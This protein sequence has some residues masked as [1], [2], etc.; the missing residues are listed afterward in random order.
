MTCDPCRFAGK[1]TLAVKYCKDCKGHFC[2][3][4]SKSHV[5]AS[6][7]KTHEL[8]SVSKTRSTKS[9]TR[10][11][12]KCQDHGAVLI[13]YCETHEALCCSVCALTSH[14]GCKKVIQ[15]S[16]AAVGKRAFRMCKDLESAI[17]RMQNH[18]EEVQAQKQEYIRSVEQQLDAVESSINMFRKSVNGILNNLEDA[19]NKK[20]DDIYKE[21]T[22]L[23][24]SH[25]KTSQTAINILNDAYKQ[26]D[27][28]LKESDSEMFIRTKRVQGVVQTYAQVLARIQPMPEKEVFR[29]IPDLSIEK[30]LGGLK[31]LGDL[32]IVI[33]QSREYEP[34]IAS[35]RQSS[36]DNRKPNFTTD[37]KVRMKTD[38]KACFITGAT[39]LFDGRVVLA[40]DSNKNVKLFGTDFKSLSSVPLDSSPRD[41]STISHTEVAATLP[42]EKMIQMFKV[43][44]KDMEKKKSLVLDIECYGIT[45]FETEIYVTSG[46]SSEREIQ[47]LNPSGE[48]SRKIRLPKGVFRYPLY[49]TIDPKSR[50]MYVADYI[51]GIIALD[52][53]GKIVFQ[54]KNTDIGTYYKGLTITTPGQIYVCTWQQNGVQRVHTDGKGLETVLTWKTSD[55]RKP[56]AAAYTSKTKRLVL[57][58]CGDKRD[59]LSIYKFY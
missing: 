15:L 7:T 42:N 51:N 38:K 23:V 43:G 35:S 18:F 19:L 30:F 58:F 4:C 20:K 46:W 54:C 45:Y 59:V 55:R 33:V 57:S 12:E 22:E 47:V 2:F 28:S 48:F 24:K 32:K 3:F 40:D 13:S 6:R 56:L 8:I 21:R 27:F 25:V 37:I 31:E 1:P 17:K 5:K 44:A 41:I 39:F 11:Q 10:I 49:I 14:K 9:S 50:I 34:S 52:M 26:L 16:E 53:A 29:F 36:S